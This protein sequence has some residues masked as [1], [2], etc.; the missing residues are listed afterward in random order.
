MGYNKPMK[1]AKV[2][3]A[4]FRAR[5]QALMAEYNAEIT[6]REARGYDRQ[7]YADGINVEIPDVYDEDGW[8]SACRVTIQL[9]KTIYPQD[10]M[11]Y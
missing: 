11:D 5:L 2:I 7:V 6:V 8:T 9:P 10:L 1:S 3:E 4:E